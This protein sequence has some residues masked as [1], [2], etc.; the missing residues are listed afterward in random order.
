MEWIKWLDLSFAYECSIYI[1]PLQQRPTG[2]SDIGYDAW[3]KRVSWLGMSGKQCVLCSLCN[4]VYPWIYADEMQSC[5][6]VL[7][8]FK[9]A[10]FAHTYFI[11]AES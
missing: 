7:L 6:Q 9:W 10:P 5:L 2:L 1:S 11:K 3:K 4:V 8:F